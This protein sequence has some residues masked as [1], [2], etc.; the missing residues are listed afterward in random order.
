M[1]TYFLGGWVGLQKNHDVLNGSFDDQTHANEVDV[2]MNVMDEDDFHCCDGIFYFH[3]LDAVDELVSV[4]YA[5]GLLDDLI[6]DGGCSTCL[7][8]GQGEGE[9]DLP[10]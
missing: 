4:A 5:M 9:G 10:N 6:Q 2:L 7:A 1:Q 8:N 3:E